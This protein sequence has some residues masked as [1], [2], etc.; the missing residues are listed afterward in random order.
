MIIKPSDTI[1]YSS[2]APLRPEQ[3]RR[4]N[5]SDF[6]ELVAGGWDIIYVPPVVAPPKTPEELLEEER[7]GMIVTP[8]QFRKA[9]NATN[10]RGDINSLL[11]NPQMSQDAKDGWEVATSW[12]RNHPLVIEFGTAL[13]MTETDIDDLFRLAATL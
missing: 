1:T 12:E 11:N 9:V 8:W 4:L 10:R 3:R 2:G 7:Q 5:G 6:D 13:G